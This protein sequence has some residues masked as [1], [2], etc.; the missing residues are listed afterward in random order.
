MS[1]LPT[2]V[3]SAWGIDPTAKYPVTI[4][5]LNAD[6]YHIACIPAAMG[7]A[8]KAH[9]LGVIDLYNESSYD[10]DDHPKLVQYHTELEDGTY[11][12]ACHEEF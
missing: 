6:L 8:A 4:A 11:C 12:G 1:T 5:T 2:H 10:S 7:E 3:L 9:D